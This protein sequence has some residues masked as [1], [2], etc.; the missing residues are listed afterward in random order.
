MRKLLGRFVA[1]LLPSVNRV[2]H[3]AETVFPRR[4]D[5]PLPQ[6]PVLIVGA[7]RSGSTLLFQVLTEALEFGYLSNLH[8]LFH[9]APSL[10]ERLVRPQ[11]W[12]EES[13][14]SSKHGVVGGLASP[15]E[16]GAYWYRFFTRKPQFV[17]GSAAAPRK[18]R[19]L[20][21]SMAALGRASGKPL[22]FKNLNCALR[23][24]PTAAA[25]PEALFI[26]ITRNV[27][28]NAQSILEARHKVLG[29][30]DRW[31]SLEPPGYERLETLP[32]EAQ[33]VEQVLS[34]NELVERHRASIGPGRFLHVSYDELCA[35]PAS[36]VAKVEAFLG[37]HGTTVERRPAALPESFPIR[38]KI[39]VEAALFAR[40][41]AYAASRGAA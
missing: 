29:R 13:T 36:A 27:V 19:A 30:Y 18:L 32:A 3:H 38:S 10:V 7:P 33:A 22:L 9:G 39:A 4:A 25:L 34:I 41:Q 15:S 35:D 14:F 20:R 21:M 26:F 1:L 17:S 23:L 5:A 24:E 28:D 11:R 16:C 8:C 40:L 6:V 37:S 31:W 2:L 12:R